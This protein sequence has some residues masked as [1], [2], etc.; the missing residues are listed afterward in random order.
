M[1][2]KL[3]NR[4]PILT[5]VIAFAATLTIS[6][7]WWDATPNEVIRDRA[8]DCGE[9]PSEHCS[10]ETFA[11]TDHPNDHYLVGYV[12]FDDQGAPYMPKQIDTLFDRLKV[13][14]RDRDLCIIIFVHGWKHN[15]AQDDSNVRDFRK[16]LND[17]A[18]ME[19]KLPAESR[20][21]VVGIYAGWRG[22]SLHATPVDENLTFRAR[23]A[24]AERVATGSIRELLARAKAFRD[25]LDQTTWKGKLLRDGEMPEQGDRLRRTRLLTIG[26]SFG[27]LIVYSALAQYFTDQAAASLLRSEFIDAGLRTEPVTDAERVVASFGDLVVVI[28]PAIEAM[29]YEPIRRLVDGRSQKQYAPWQAPVLV[30]VTSVGDSWQSTHLGDLATGF[31]FP[32]GR[33]F[34]TLSEHIF[35]SFRADEYDEAIRAFGHYSDFW[36]HRLTN[37]NPHTP[38]SLPEPD[39]KAECSDFEAF[40]AEFRPLGYLSRGWVRRYASGAQLTHINDSKPDPNNPFWVVRADPSIIIDHNDI[41]EP[42]F[43]GFVRQLYDDIVLLKDN[44]KQCPYL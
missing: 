15:D 23:K 41:A 33:R 31:L 2:W 34:S 16:L 6:A 10:I 27:G 40:N 8:G 3:W 24:A 44:G 13:E 11:V 43:E 14:S 32:L 7:A 12:E 38:L 17:V 18:I 20:R 22:L 19:Q 25:L 35:G 9:H 42:V 21:K 29:R 5:I 26:H 36:T 37:T 4:C 39:P 30:E 28:N 1:V